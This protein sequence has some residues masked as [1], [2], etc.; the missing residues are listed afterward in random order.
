MSAFREDGEAGLALPQAEETFPLSPEQRAALALWGGDARANRSSLL[1]QVQIRGVL[2]VARLKASVERARTLHGALRAAIQPVPGYRGLR[3]RYLAEAPAVHWQ[4]LDLRGSGDGQAALASWQAAWRAEPLAIERGELLRAALVRT[5]DAQYTLLCA[6]S[7]LAADAGSLRQLL[8]QIARSYVHGSAAL[9]EEVFQY[10]QFVEWRRDLEEG[11]DAAEGRAYWQRYLAGSKSLLAPRLLFRHRSARAG[12][13]VEGR[14]CAPERNDTG[15]RV[16]VGRAVDRLF[17]ARIAASAEAMDVSLAVL[18]QAVWWLLLARLSDFTDFLGGW[19]H[20]CRRDYEPM[21][22]ALGV[23]DKVLPIVV[24]PRADERFA[25]WLTRLQE[26][27]REHADLQEYWTIDAPPISQHLTV[28]FALH[29]APALAGAEAWRLEPP[30]A[31]PCFELALHA[32]WGDSEAALAVYADPSSYSRAASERLLLQYETLLASAIEQPA[33]MISELT[34][35]GAAERD[36]LLAVQGARVDFGAATVAD[37]VAH[38]ARQTPDAPALEAEGHRLSYRELDARVNR[39]AH[40]L[41]AQGVSS[42]TLVALELPRSSDLVVAM[43]AAFRA[44]A[45]YLPL[46]PEWPAGRRAALLADAQPALVLHAHAGTEDRVGPWRAAALEGL[47]LNSLPSTPPARPAVL[48]DV[49]YVLYTSGSTGRPKGVVI[50][51]RQLLNYVAAASQAMALSDARRW[52]LTSS[53]VADLGNTALFGALFHGACLVVAGEQELKDA[54]AFAHFMAERAID[55]LKI[56]P[57]HLE[58]LLEC[59]KPW[60]PRTLVL[61]GE[62]A[63]RSLIERIRRLA[64]QCEIYNHYGPTETTVGVMVH[65]VVQDDV[66][67]E[68][69]PLSRV[70]ANSRIYVLDAKRGLAPTGALGEVYVGGAQVARGYL[71]RELEGPFLSDPWSPGE[72]LYR[73]GDLAYVLAEGALVLAGRADHQVKIRGFRVEPAELEAVLLA[74]PGVRQAAVMVRTEASAG[75]ELWAFLVAE[76]EVSSERGQHALQQQLSALLPAYMLPARYVALASF[77]RLA[78]GKID[79]VALMAR[80]QE[81]LPKTATAPRDDVEFVLAA[82]LSELLGRE[83]VDVEADFFALG[84]HSLLAIKLVARVRKLLEVNLA[85]GMVFE[86]PSVAA[87]AAALRDA[88]SDLEQL[89]RLAGLQRAG[90][91]STASK[92]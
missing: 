43:L 10:A 12:A 21:R 78:N 83:V 50:E 32:S 34:I 3:Q 80:V 68:V 81:E 70:L 79:R 20:D 37:F 6:V 62:A 27:M 67:T 9:P 58:A 75:S 13:A 60:L 22:G 18:L 52:A 42:G 16:R 40:W 11:D 35:V 65:R 66:A 51:H 33:A 5:A 69:L 19:Q 61:G 59:A 57:S 77:P 41:K 47:D 82:C 73:T 49:A 55:A 88:S 15:E 23:F 74:Q 91:T 28:G 4:E 29:D 90:R 7:A 45:G 87:L 1:L 84:V 25:T 38:W 89:R 64:P 53:V 30:E 92:T 56:V 2:D 46:E 48:E 39:L 63:A 31:P 14:V 86:H 54:D 8:E 72:R 71:R 76:G 26:A 36:A 17:A 24:G 85:P 44:G